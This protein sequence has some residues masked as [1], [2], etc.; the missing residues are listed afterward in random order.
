M[1]SI[2]TIRSLSQDDWNMYRALRLKALEESPEA[3]LTTL[4]EAQNRP[5]REWRERLT[6]LDPKWD[7]PLIA[8]VGEIP[9]GMAW[10]YVTRDRKGEGQLLQMWVDPRFRGRGIGAGLV[11]RVVDWARSLGLLSLSLGVSE[12]Q[13]EARRLYERCGFRS[14]GNAE[15]QPPGSGHRITLMSLALHPGDTRDN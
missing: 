5:E 13:P 3:F 8:W 12:T 15:Q 7:L 14:A 10:G 2:C 1:D 6:S 11:R 4:T 9:A